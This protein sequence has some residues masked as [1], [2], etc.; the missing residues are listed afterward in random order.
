MVVRA[1]LTPK[2]DGSWGMSVDSHVI[3]KIIIKYR[4]PTPRLDGMLDL[5]TSAFVFSNIDLHS[6]YHQNRIRL[7]DESKTAFTTKDGHYKWL[8]M[9]FGLANAPSKFL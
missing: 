1:L 3:N 6:G 4:Y 5:M 8:V 9:P 7:A 2:K